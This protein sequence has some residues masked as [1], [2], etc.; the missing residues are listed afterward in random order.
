MLIK[1]GLKIRKLIS[2]RSF[3]WGSKEDKQPNLITKE[4]ELKVMQYRG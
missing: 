4:E 2:K 3:L 1:T